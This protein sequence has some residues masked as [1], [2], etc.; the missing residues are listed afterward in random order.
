MHC[1]F[2]IPQQHFDEIQIYPPFI[3]C[4]P[5]LCGFACVFRIIVPLKGPISVQLQLS[6]R[7]PHTIFKHSLIRYRIKSVTAVCPVPEAVKRPQTITFPPPRFTVGIRVIHRKSRL[8]SVPNMPSV[9]EAQQ[10]PLIR[11]PRAHY[12]N[13]LVYMFAGELELCFF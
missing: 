11:L 4:E 3:L 8:W 9:T 7:W 1:P 6:D 12:Y 10:L 13:R 5:V 2:R